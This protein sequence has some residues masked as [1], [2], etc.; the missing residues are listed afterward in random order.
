[1]PNSSVSSEVIDDWAAQ[2][3]IADLPHG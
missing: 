3:K 2:E 1:M